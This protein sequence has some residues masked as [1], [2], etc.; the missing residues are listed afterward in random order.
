MKRI[1]TIAAAL[2]ITAS[3]WA[4]APEKMSYQAVV[5]DGNNALVTSTAVGMQISILQGS[6]SGAAVYTETQTPTTNANGLVSI[7]IGGGTLISGDFSAINWTD[8]PYFIKTETDPTGGLTYTIAGASELLSVPYALHSATADSL[9]GGFSYTETDPVYA[10]SLSAGITTVDTSNW[11]SKLAAE[12]QALSISNDTIYLTGGS[13]V[14]LPAAGGSGWG[15]S[16]NSGLDDSNF[17]GRTDYGALN[18]KT[19]NKPAGQVHPTSN[20]TSFGYEAGNV[21]NTTGSSNTAIGHQAMASQTNASNNTAVGSKA[22]NANT[23]SNNVALGSMAMEKSTSGNSNVAVG[24]EAL[25]KN[26]SGSANV[27]IGQGSMY[28]NN[29]SQGVGVGYFALGSNVDGQNNVAVGY[30]AISSG[31]APNFNTGVGSDALKNCSSYQNV[32]LG[33]SALKANTSGHYNTA[34]GASAMFANTTGQSNTASGRNVLYKNTTGFYNVASGERAMY[35]STIGEKNTA[36][37]TYALEQDTLGNNNTAVGYKALSTLNVGSDNT[38]IGFQTIIS[39]ASSNASAIGANAS[40]SMSDGMVF[41]DA[42]VIAWGFGVT[43]G[44][45]EAIKVGTSAT[46]GNGALLTTGGVWTNASDRTKKHDIKPIVYGLADVLKLNPVSYKMKATNYQD[47]G[48]I[49]Q[50]VK[51]VIPEVVYGEE[52]SMTM[53]YGQL[54]AV[55]TQAIQDQQKLIDELKSDN[56]SLKAELSSLKSSNDIRMNKIEQLLNASIAKQHTASK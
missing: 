14:V 4:Q 31:S 32:G 22:L 35:H 54:T 47:V 40:C 39:D 20:R 7:E 3:A 5:R 1:I 6:T 9:I 2:I 42:N 8:G 18:F 33:W 26:T 25:G 12:I 34:L 56:N 55:L 27:S 15:V 24:T 17:I 29:S 16:G 49:A 51:K 45:G 30:Q 23:G 11:N 41:G 44:S 48:F 28:Q 38:A 21:E 46:N 53:S 10:A 50:D 13:S 43:P 19:N 36:I 52:G 37:G